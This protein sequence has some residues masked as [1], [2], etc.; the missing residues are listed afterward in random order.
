MFS[1]MAD[2]PILFFTTAPQGRVKESE[3]VISLMES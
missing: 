3:I 1:L 2:L